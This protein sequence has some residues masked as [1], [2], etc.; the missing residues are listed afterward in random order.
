MGNNVESTRNTSQTFVKE[1]LKIRK[2]NLK[3][4]KDQAMELNHVTVK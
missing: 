3:K 1:I 2:K 4:K